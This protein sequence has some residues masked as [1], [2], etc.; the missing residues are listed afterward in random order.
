MPVDLT[1]LTALATAGVAA[2]V[3]WALT[4][5]RR[6]VD[7]RLDHEVATERS[8]LER[9]VLGNVQ[10]EADGEPTKASSTESDESDQ[11]TRLLIEY[12]AHGLAQAKR[13]FVASLVSSMLGGAV[14]L[15][16][17]ALA[18]FKAE[19]TGGQ[20][21]SIVVSLAGVL[22]NAT[23]VLFHRQSHR[24][25]LHMEGQTTLLRQDMRADRESHDALALLSDVESGAL[26]DQL[27]AGLI[28][29]LANAKLPSFDPGVH[30]R[31]SLI[32]QPVPSSNGDPI[33]G[34]NNG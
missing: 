24:A 4:I 8:R 11:F 29:R 32:D 27:R 25:L 20:Y 1:A 7:R 26:R 10:T 14:L 17:V 15:V 22:T 6:W 5:A 30:L 2:V 19:S 12:Y 23:G 31:K 34:V 3:S 16:G 18:I 21:A 28:L 9:S 33:S 13:S